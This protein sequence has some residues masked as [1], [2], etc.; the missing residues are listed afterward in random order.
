MRC[1]LPDEDAT[2]RLGA[3]L[4][5]SCP[6][7]SGLLLT[8]RGE[9][10]AGKSTLAR[11][12]LRGLGA[13]GTIRSPTYTLAEPYSTTE[14]PVLHMDLYRLAG[15]DELESLGYRD[16]REQHRLLIVEWP[17]RAGGSL[18]PIDLDLEL[19]YSGSGREARLEARSD[20]GKA[21][22]CALR[23]A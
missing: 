21:W 13:S 6:G 5:A 22:L 18:G 2:C 15:A 11:A 19:T 20:P 7:G 10:G 8:L 16:W 4:A 17:E 23:A 12:L 3:Q 14:G 1:W 9:L